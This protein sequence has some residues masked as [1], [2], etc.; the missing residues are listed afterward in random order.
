MTTSEI[1]QWL[2]FL[3]LDG[4]ISETLIEDKMSGE[5]RRVETI[6]YYAIKHIF[7]LQNACYIK[8][9][10]MDEEVSE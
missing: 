2:L 6:A 10:Q 1:M 9:A 5:K 3:Q 4:R 8:G 7:E